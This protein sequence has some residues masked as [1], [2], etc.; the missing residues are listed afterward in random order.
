MSMRTEY[1]QDFLPDAGL[2]DDSLEHRHLGTV[3]L[4]QIR[5]GKGIDLPV[6]IVVAKNFRESFP[7]DK[8]FLTVERDLIMFDYL[9]NGI[10]PQFLAITKADQMELMI[11]V[12][13]QCLQI[14]FLGG[15]K[16]VCAVFS[17]LMLIRKN[18]KTVCFRVKWY[19]KS[20]FARI[21]LHGF[22]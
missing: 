11:I 3:Y 14:I 9:K 12:I 18:N 2:Q 20:V 5:R 4:L 22:L 21:V 8:F 16:I 13:F 1:A 19:D 15:H 6:K 17:T 10:F 7:D